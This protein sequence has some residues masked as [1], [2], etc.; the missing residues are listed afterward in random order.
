MLSS[1]AGQPRTAVALCPIFSFVIPGRF[2]QRAWFG[3]LLLLCLLS[4]G[5]WAQEPARPA[6]QGFVEEVHFHPETRRLRVAGWAASELP[7][8]FV[9]NIA[10]RLGEQEI[11][12]GRIER[13][14]RP[15]VAQHTGR[16]DWLW[17]G[18]TV[19]V[20]VPDSVSPGPHAVTLQ[21]RLS[22][23]GSFDL[24][25][26]DTARKPVE[27]PA[28]PAAHGLLA[29][30]AFAL[31][32]PVL[33]LVGAGSTG[34]SGWAPLQRLLRH[35]R[36]VFAATVLLAFVLLVG[37]GL[38]GSSLQIALS[39]SGI[40]QHD[41]RVLAGEL[42]PIRS[43]EWEVITPMALSQRTQQPAWP[44]QNASWGLDGHNMLVVGMTGVP[45]AHLSALAKPATWGFLA[46]DLRRGLAWSWWFPF[47]ACFAALWLLLQRMFQLEWRLAAGLAA[48]FAVAPYSVVFSGWPAYVAFF[49]LMGLVLAD[50]VL[51]S[52]SLPLALAGGAALGVCMAGFALVLYPA[53]QISLAYL[54]VP[55]ALGWWYSRRRELHFGLAQG[56]ALVLAMAVAAV[57]LGAWW[58]DAAPAVKAIRATV[59]PGQR[60]AEVGGDIDSWFLLKGLLAPVL[61]YAPPALASAVDSSY[62][63]LLLPVAAALLYAWTRARQVPLVSLLPALYMLGVLWFMYIGFAP[64]FA[65]WSMWGSSTSQRQDL[66][67]GLAQTL[68]LAW[69][70]ALAARAPAMPGAPAAPRAG[71]PQPVAALVALLAAWLTW[72][73][74]RW[75]PSAADVMVPWL[76]RLLS[77]AAVAL[78]AFWLLIGRTAAFALLY[79]GWMLGSAL[80]FNPLVQ[81]PASVALDARLQQ[82]LAAVGPGVPAPDGPRGVAVVGPRVWAVVLPATGVPVVNSVFYAPP[83]AFWQRMDP[84]GLKTVVHN[85]YQRL[86]LEL[87]PVAAE[88][89]HRIETPRLDEVRVTLDPARFDFRQL[90]A[91][92]VL[93]A[94]K[95]R[96]ALDA[97]TSL[98]RLDQTDVWV[99]Y[100]VQALPQ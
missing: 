91:Q 18:F 92:T 3:L 67:L 21:A 69:L 75:L 34:S 59:Y 14:D 85:R 72:V 86:L 10:I 90:G 79:C 100:Q 9:S 50:G 60:L 52:R 47:F 55:L 44:V 29:L 25:V 36:R 63:L 12:R 49:P 1:L 95:D 22:S 64:W 4:F 42:R 46:F 80:W 20:P 87:A 62:F 32:L 11:Y 53:W 66:G 97:N 81:A 43:D 83:K 17:S 2:F 98:R 48:A 70:L 61:M 26:A 93:A 82:Q 16:D 15:G 37:A 76:F 57:L 33:V 13:F 45:V 51:R 40:T 58:A 30:A 35:P 23:G 6:G 54:L 39:G 99:L 65:R 78:A 28:V 8:V 88:A 89:T 5:A 71:M 31:L 96:P 84:Q 41:G 68:L 24:G 56:L 73:S 7:N 38:S 74:Y 27:V 77:V 19:E 94:P